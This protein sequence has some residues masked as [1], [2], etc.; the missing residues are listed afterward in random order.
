MGRT[1]INCVFEQNNHGTVLV[2]GSSDHYVGEYR[3][4]FRDI[5]DWKILPKGYK[6]T[7]END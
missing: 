5:S 1:R 6:I 2:A 7:L 3:T 4:T